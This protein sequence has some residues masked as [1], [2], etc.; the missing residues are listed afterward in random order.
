[1]VDTATQRAYWSHRQ[2]LDG[3]LAG[4]TS[5]QVLERIGW[6]R[7]VGGTTPYLTL[8]G[9]AGLRRAEVDAD[10]AALRIHELPS[11]R[12]CTHVLPARDF[13]LAPQVGGGASSVGELRTAEK[14]GVTRAEV[15]MLADRVLDQL[16][17][18]GDADPAGLRRSLG[19]AVRSLGEEG[20]RRGITTTLPLAIGV[21]QADSRIR[22]VPVDGRLDQQ[23]FRYT[24]W[25]DVPRF[26]GTV[27]DARAVLAQRYWEWIGVAS[28]AHFRWFSGFTVAATKRAVADLALVPVDETGLLATAATVAELES[29][30][31]PSTPQVTLIGWLDSLVLLRRDLDGIT[32]AVDR[33]HPLLVPARGTAAGGSL[34]DLPHQGIVDRGRLIGLWDYDPDSADIV[35]APITKLTAAQRVATMDA[36][37]RTAAYV[38][39][40]LGD[41]RGMSLD[42]PRARAPRLAA[43]RAHAE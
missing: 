8:F 35:W 19:D 6:A 31:V 27:D 22:R 1:M 14:L 33:A 5:A 13:A 7:S 40:D 12:D 16:R 10:V 11:A 24:P 32:D 26:A 20:K 34:T 15:D 21:L 39:E 25:P 36:V 17:T 29:Y 42:S 18:G 2:G 3:S 38:R 4:A 37:G 30:A 23:R 43:L 41:N 9:R 28:L